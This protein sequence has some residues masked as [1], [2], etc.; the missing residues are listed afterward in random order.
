MTG[1]PKNEGW[2][3]LTNNPEWPT[4]GSTALESMFNVRIGRLEKAIGRQM[5]INA[6][7]EEFIFGPSQEEW[8][9]HDKKFQ[10]ALTIP[11]VDQ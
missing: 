11:L 1:H 6:A 4:N 3:P 9:E 7:L 8:P 2:H 5:I 10:L